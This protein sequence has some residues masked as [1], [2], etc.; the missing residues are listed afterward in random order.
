MS[1]ILQSALATVLLASTGTAFAVSNNI[2]A[3]YGTIALPFTHSVGDTFVSNGAGDYLD[4]LGNAV[5][6]ATIS[7]PIVSAPGNADYNFYDDFEFT[8]P[9]SSGSLTASAIS[10][11]FAS[12]FGIDNLQLRLY[13]TAGG[14]TTG[15]ASGLVSAWSQVIPA[16]S[17][18]STIISTFASPVSLSAGAQYTLEVR[19]K[20]LASGASY[21]GN[22]NIAA[23]PEP[24]SLALILAGLSVAGFM[25]RRQS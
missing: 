8:L 13:N 11:D 23:V 22:F 20:I 9:S 17:G 14:L 16:G 21:G 3:N 12:V 10:V 7:K 25:I 2:E 6:S 18:V 1:R 5:S 19:G 15:G 4:Q 24:A